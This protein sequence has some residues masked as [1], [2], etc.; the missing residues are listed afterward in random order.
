MGY[1]NIL[2]PKHWAFTLT[3]THTH[4]SN[5][6]KA[7]STSI[8]SLFGLFVSFLFFSVVLLFVCAHWWNMKCFPSLP[9]FIMLLF[10]LARSQAIMQHRCYAKFFP[11]FFFPVLSF[12]PSIA[13]M[14][15]GYKVSLPIPYIFSNICTCYSESNWDLEA[16]LSWKT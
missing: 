7:I 5:S 9:I 2:Y 3:G 11:K 15:I 16:A 13:R 4:T 6:N 14:R 10:I 1:K 8:K 12:A